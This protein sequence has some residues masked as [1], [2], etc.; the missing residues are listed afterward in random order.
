VLHGAVLIA[1]AF[2]GVQIYGMV[3]PSLRGV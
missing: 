3:R 2:E 1:N